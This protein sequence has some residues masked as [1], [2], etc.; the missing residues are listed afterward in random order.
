MLEYCLLS[1]ISSRK[2]SLSRR[3][4][5]P[6][7]RHV[8]VVTHD[9][10][11]ALVVAQH[12]GRV[13]HVQGDRVPVIEVEVSGVHL[14]GGHFEG[15]DLGVGLGGD[16]P[17]LLE[18]EAEA[19]LAAFVLALE[20]HPLGVSDEARPDGEVQRN[21]QLRGR[22][23]SP[24]LDL[25][26]SALGDASHQVL[27]V[28]ETVRLEPNH[29]LHGHSRGEGAVAAGLRWGGGRCEEGVRVSIE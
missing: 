19:A 25:E 23:V 24:Q 12:Q 6:V 3:L 4:V 14:E 13:V 21:G 9:D 11:L 16:G 2:T 7:R 20:L 15:R 1:R 17:L 22:T 8:A 10:E 27:V 28:R 26:L 18:H 29:Y 5:S